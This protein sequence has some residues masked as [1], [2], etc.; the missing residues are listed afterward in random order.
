VT[1]QKRSHYKGGRQHRHIVRVSPE[2]EAV[3]LQGAARQGVNVVQFLVESATAMAAS[4][5]GPVETVTGRRRRMEELFAARHALAEVALQARRIGVNVNQVAKA[6]N[7]GQELPV[8]AMRG[9]LVDADQLLRTAREVAGRI[10][11]AIDELAALGV[12]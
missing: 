9:Y 1:Q 2:E 4:E 10:D 6:A 12:S 11:V 5:D 3:L 7:T 8:D